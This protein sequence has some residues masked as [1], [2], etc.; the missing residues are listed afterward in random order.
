MPDSWLRWLA[1]SGVIIVLAYW[2]IAEIKTAKANS[3][4]SG[5][6]RSARWLIRSLPLVG[7]I[8]IILQLLGAVNI[9]L[10]VSNKTTYVLVAAG[11]LLFWPT[12]ILALWS[13]REIGRNWAHAADYQ[14]IKGQAL[15]E[16]GPYAYIRHPIYAAMLG[17]FI[18]A[19]MIVM[20]WLIMLAVPLAWFLVAQSRREEAILLAEFGE[21]YRRYMRRTGMF[22]PLVI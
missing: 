13:R 10:P 9:P 6:S 5:Y 1:V 15:V 12:V 2:H 20:S 4:R 3:A 16:N 8:L 11:H 22:L 18:G 19:E 14:I 17:I 7:G 21:Q